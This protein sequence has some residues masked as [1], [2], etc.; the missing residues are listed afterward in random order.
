MKMHPIANASYQRIKPAIHKLKREALETLLGYECFSD[1]YNKTRLWATRQQR[2]QQPSSQNAEFSYELNEVSAITSAKN[3]AKL[4]ALF[5]ATS[6][7][8]RIKPDKTFKRET[9]AFIHAITESLPA[10]ERCF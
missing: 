5:R 6:R 8:G 7:N 10:T 3:Y 9:D 4:M 2:T 1:F